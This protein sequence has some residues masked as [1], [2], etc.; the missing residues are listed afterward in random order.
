MK[1]LREQIETLNSLDQE[2]FVDK[3]FEYLRRHVPDAG[4]GKEEVLRQALSEE[5]EKARMYDLVTEQEVATFVMTSWLLGR[6]F[7]DRFPAAKTV[8]NSPAYSADEKADWLSR[9]TREMFG[10]LGKQD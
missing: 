10:A 6:D 9:W 7:V 4:Q 5:I 1:I 2:R 8:L 3:L